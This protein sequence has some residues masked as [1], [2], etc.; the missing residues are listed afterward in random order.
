M[1]TPLDGPDAP[2]N[3]TAT[4]RAARRRS[5]VAVRPPPPAPDLEWNAI[6][7]VLESIDAPD[8][9]PRAAVE[10]VI[11]LLPA[12]TARRASEKA[13]REEAAAREHLNALRAAVNERCAAGR[14]A[15]IEQD[16][17]A[18]TAVRSHLA[19]ASKALGL[20][21]KPR[22]IDPTKR[23]RDR[24]GAGPLLHIPTPIGTLNEFTRGGLIAGRLCV[25]GG[26]P[27][28][29]KTSLAVQLAHHAALHGYAVAFHAVDEDSEGVE[30]RIGQACGLALEDLERR[31]PE[32]LRYL[33]D[34]LEEVP[35]M[36]IVDE[37]EDAMTVEDTA[38][39]LVELGRRHGSPGLVLVV[40]SLQ[41]A[42]VRGIE[43][44]RTAKDRADMVT[45]TLKS[46]ARRTGALVIVTSELARGA[47]RAKNT[48]ERTEAMAAFKESGSIEYAMTIGLVLT[49]VKGEANVVRVDVPKCK[50]G[51]R[52]AFL[53]RRNPWRCTYEDGGRVED[54]DEDARQGSGAAPAD[55][56]IERDM[57][58]ARHV[59]RSHPGIA[60]IDAWVDEM[61]I[62]KSRARAACR[63]LITRGEVE[64]RRERGRP[65]FFWRP[66]PS[67]PS[68]PTAEHDGGPDV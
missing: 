62:N 68:A 31:D 48:R 60:G 40:D 4:P 58:R 49:N 61:G 19:A 52:G 32:A 33:A 59:L 29:G 63:R 64:D 11:D 10:R 17:A 55:A 22:R 18:H 12:L 16:D 35:N 25:S 56:Q 27:D 34:R 42:R 23:V 15:A 20:Q 9:D 46:I 57:E 13:R 65:R 30:C 66:P 54:E 24:I 38:D 37:D 21:G 8:A 53:L 3:D 45:A 41:T 28:A 1:R 43:N 5:V 26:A 51:T 47:Y 67:E 36:V 39:V 2:A 14:D 7:A 50:R 6:G 44:A